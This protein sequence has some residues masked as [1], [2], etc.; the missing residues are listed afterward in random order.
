MRFGVGGERHTLEQVGERFAITSNRVRQIEAKAWKKILERSAI[1]KVIS[2]Y[3]NLKKIGRNYLGLCPFHVE[4]TP[5]FTVNEEKGI[6]HCFGCG[7][8]GSLFNF[9][10]LI[11]CVTR[12]Q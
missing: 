3:I 2:N 9:K 7:V 8:G 12:R 10:V 11:R 5:S 1:V 6:F 4:K